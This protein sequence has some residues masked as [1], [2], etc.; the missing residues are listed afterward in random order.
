MLGLVE[1]EDGEILFNS[2]PILTPYSTYLR[3]KIQMVLIRNWPFSESIHY[4]VQN[5]GQ[6]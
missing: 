2:E 3:Q 5:F 6:T 4:I 1:K